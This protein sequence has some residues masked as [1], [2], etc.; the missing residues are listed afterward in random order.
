MLPRPTREAGQAAKDIET[1]GFCIVPDA[2]PK[3][4][5]ERVHDAIY[6]AASE[7][8]ARGREQK[9]DWTTRTTIQINAYGTCSAATRPS[10][11]WSRTRWRSAW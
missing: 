6:R 10:P 5:L 2:L 4:R 8:R 11:T 9:F 1:F 3:P 7:D